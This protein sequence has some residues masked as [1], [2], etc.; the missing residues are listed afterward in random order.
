MHAIKHCRKNL[1]GYGRLM[2]F[3]HI[4][5]LIRGNEIG[6]NNADSS[7]RIY[8]HQFSDFFMAES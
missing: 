1:N 4:R 6:G 3:M 8:A 7:V 5:K 2:Y